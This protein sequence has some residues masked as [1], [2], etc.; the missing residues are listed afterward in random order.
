[1]FISLQ[2]VVVVVSRVRSGLAS[3]PAP[4]GL[5]VQQAAA[6]GGLKVTRGENTLKHTKQQHAAA[7]T[8]KLFL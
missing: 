8:I 4:P 6:G 2:V 7:S 3:D 1:M 5:S